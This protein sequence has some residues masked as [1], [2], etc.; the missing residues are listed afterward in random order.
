MPLA[1]GFFLLSFFVDVD[2]ALARI[3]QLG[4]A[5]DIR[6]IDVDSPR[7]PVPMATLRD[8]DGVLVERVGAAA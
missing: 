1:P 5:T 2:D 7:G 4:L 3:E 8:P 6:R